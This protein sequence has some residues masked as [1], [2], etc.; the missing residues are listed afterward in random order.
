MKLNRKN[1]RKLI[2]EVLTESKVNR[3]P[4]YA[5]NPAFLYQ[6][7][8]KP[9]PGNVELYQNMAKPSQFKVDGPDLESALRA[10]KKENNVKNLEGRYEVILQHLV[11]SRYYTPA[12]KSFLMDEFRLILRDMENYMTHELDANTLARIT[13]AGKDDDD[14]LS[15]RKIIYDFFKFG[16]GN[17]EH[18]GFAGF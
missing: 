10:M 9:G 16:K 4:I 8:A 5:R 2:N 15:P 18:D 6:N 7:I 11:D 13:S 14:P 3:N 1:L 17:L 12:N